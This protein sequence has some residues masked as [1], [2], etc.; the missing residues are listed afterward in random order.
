MRPGRLLQAESW[1]EEHRAA[2]EGRLDRLGKFL[3]ELQSKEE[4]L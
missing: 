4:K 1:I 2:W 3:S